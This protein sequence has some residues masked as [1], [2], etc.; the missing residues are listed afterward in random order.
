MQQIQQQ[1]PPLPTPS[2]Q[3]HQQQQQQPLCWVAEIGGY[4]AA[5]L[6]MQPA[7]QQQPKQGRQG[8][9]LEVLLAAVFPDMDQSA[10]VFAA[11]ASYAL[12]Q[13]LADRGVAE[14]AQGNL[15]LLPAMQRHAATDA[16]GAPPASGAPGALLLRFT[17]SISSTDR[18]LQ[19]Q[20]Q[21]RSLAYAAGCSLDL[22]AS[23]VTAHMQDLAA[24][25]PDGGPDAAAAASAG[26]SAAAAADA[27]S[28]AAVVKAAR[29]LSS[30]WTDG[31][32]ASPGAEEAAAE[33]LFA[34]ATAVVTG[35]MEAAGFPSECGLQNAASQREA[36]H[37][38]APTPSPHQP[39]I[40]PL[41][42]PSLAVSLSLIIALPPRLH[43]RAADSFTSA[44]PLMDAGL[45]SL[46]MLKLARWVGGVLLG[47][48]MVLV[49]IGCATLLRHINCGLP[50]PH[51]PTAAASCLRPW[52]WPSLPLFSS[53]ILPSR[54][55]AAT[56]WQHRCVH[57]V[58]A[59]CPSC[60]S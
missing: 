34:D 5:A 46:D 45:D 53:T 49:K 12:Q 48:R 43:C 57:G 10:E 38:T 59:N 20:W 16:S 32:A 2:G 11:L 60:S 50:C 14:V 23:A 39:R 56:S 15:L 42:R 33:E 40:T 21:Q 58:P 8:Q 6:M 51:L 35:F 36:S 19:Q 37:H 4:P 54:P 17:S 30:L 22:L 24:G 13:L 26:M 44:T 55:C 52:A 47:G 3:Q 18:G 7:D 29:R 31:P 27:A 41:G 28:V 1:L 9:V 25:G